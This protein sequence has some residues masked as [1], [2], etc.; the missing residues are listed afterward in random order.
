[1][2]QAVWMAAL[3]QCR[4]RQEPLA[5]IRL[6]LNAGRVMLSPLTAQQSI[7]ALDSM[8]TWFTSGEYL[9]FIFRL[10]RTLVSRRPPA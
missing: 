8:Q 4:V 10:K 5:S 1:M 2:R 9:I 6:K 3:A 7:E